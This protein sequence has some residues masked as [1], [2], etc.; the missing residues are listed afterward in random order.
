MAGA[1]EGQRTQNNYYELSAVVFFKFMKFFIAEQF[2][3]LIRV[4]RY[5]INPVKKA[6]NVV[7]NISTNLA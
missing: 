1:V 6:T 7:F 3:F 5:F 4:A 2:K